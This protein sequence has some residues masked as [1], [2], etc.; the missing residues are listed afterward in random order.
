[1]L[2]EL[3]DKVKIVGSQSEFRGRAGHVTSL[4]YI[5]DNNNIGVDIDN[6][7]YDPTIHYYNESDLVKLNHWLFTYPLYIFV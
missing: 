2:F 5:R 7:H 3:G 6:D 1:M 4:I